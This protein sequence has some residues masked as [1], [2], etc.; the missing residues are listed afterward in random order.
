M[1]GSVQRLKA[2]AAPRRRGPVG[3]GRPLLVAVLAGVLGALLAVAGARALRPPGF[4]TK[5]LRATEISPAE[6]AEREADYSPLYLAVA[7]WVVPRWGAR[8]LL[9]LNVLA[10]AATA[11]G[12]ATTV[13]LTVGGG[14]GLAAGVAAAVYR[15]FLV[16]T[17][18]LEPELILL[19]LLAGALLAGTLARLQDCPSRRAWLAG[20]AGVALGLAGTVRPVYLALL[21]AWGRWLE[22]R[23]GKTG[24]GRPLLFLLAGAA[25]VLTPWVVHRASTPGGAVV[26]NPGPVLY[27]GNGPQALGAP[28]VPPEL[29]KELESL[30]G[31]GGDWAH[32]GYRQVAAAALGG[33]VTVSESNRYWARLVLES[34]RAQ[35]QRTVRLALAK[36]AYAWGPYEFHDLPE[37]EELDRR[38]RRWLPWGFGVLAVL[39]VLAAPGLARAVPATVG[40]ASLALLSAGVQVV[41]Y[42]SARQRLPL[43]LALL[44]LIPLGLRRLVGVPGRRL[45]LVGVAGLA[46]AGGLGWVTSP[47]ANYRHAQLSALLGPAPPAPLATFLDGR[48]WRPQEAVAAERIVLFPQLARERGWEGATGFLAPALSSRLAWLR[49]RA[50]QLTA[51]AAAEAGR[52][53]AVDVACRAASETP[54]ALLAAALCAVGRGGEQGERGGEGWRPPGV[55][56]VS[57]RLALVRARLAL[58][59][60]SAARDLAAP[61]GETF[62]ELLTAPYRW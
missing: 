10:H 39:L 44:V 2:D 26:M 30:R 19:A 52:P 27:E 33:P 47:L 31:E 5:Y 36:V 22:W 28:G 25:T 61:L 49:G 60:V 8:G 13:T 9:V 38:L 16:Y 20:A 57:A 37:A 15:P 41:F 58:G 43:A 54:G 50:G 23:K 51:L 12:V 55:D 17:A 4:F 48:A 24:Q 21:P 7:R 34:L 59:Q 46:L 45:G 56:A 42:A 35:P 6:A 32:V 40:P 1:M 62:P 53:E 11:A 3:V 14:W 29:V 18:I